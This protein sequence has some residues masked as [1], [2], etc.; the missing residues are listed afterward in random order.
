MLLLQDI[1]NACALALIHF[2]SILSF[3]MASFCKR[4]LS[5][6]HV[7]LSFLTQMQSSQAKSKA[8]QE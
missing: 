5:D 7:G 2:P 4:Q 1:P 6:L 8:N 3:K